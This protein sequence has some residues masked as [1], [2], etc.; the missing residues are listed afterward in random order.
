MSIRRI[1]M[2]MNL[3]SMNVEHVLRLSAFS[4]KQAQ[5][6]RVEGRCS[7]DFIF[8][9]FLSLFFLF[10]LE[11]SL[12]SALKITQKFKVMTHHSNLRR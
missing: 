6:E 12:V 10:P 2:K 5:L 3:L 4:R 9:I 1:I 11:I 8:L 7:N